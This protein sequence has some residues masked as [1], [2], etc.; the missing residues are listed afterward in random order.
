MGRLSHPAICAAI[1]RLC[2]CGILASPSA[3]AKGL[4]DVNEAARDVCETAA[5]MNMDRAK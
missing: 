2:R 5:P 3:G 1:K 4:R